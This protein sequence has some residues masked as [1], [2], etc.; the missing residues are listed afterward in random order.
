MQLISKYSKG[1]PISLCLIDIFCK[2]T[3]II[4]FKEKKGITITNA[5]RKILDESSIKPNKICVD[6]SSEF[7]K[8]Q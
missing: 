1:F 5:F 4:P 7:I 3:W 6:K 8:D 2:Y